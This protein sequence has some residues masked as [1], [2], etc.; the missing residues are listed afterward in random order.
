M[1]FLETNRKAFTALSDGSL[2]SSVWQTY[3]QRNCTLCNRW[4]RGRKILSHI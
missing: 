1:H 3:Y 4:V 2:N